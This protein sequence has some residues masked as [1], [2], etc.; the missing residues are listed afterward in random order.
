MGR[1]L[2]R[3]CL[4]FLSFL[5]V[6]LTQTVK[7]VVIGSKQPLLAFP[8][9]DVTLPCHIYPRASAVDM[10]VR[11][12][13]QVIQTPVHLYE[14][15]RDRTD[16]QDRD[17]RSR[18]YLDRAGLHD[19]D[20]SLKLNNLQVSDNGLYNCLA[21]D[22]LWYGRGQAELVVRALGS[23]PTVTL[24]GSEAEQTH[25][26]CRS[27]GWY[28]PPALTWADGHGNDVTALSSTA[29]ERD[30]RGLLRVS[31]HIPVR[32][33]SGVFACLLRSTAPESDGETQVRVSKDFFPAVS[34]WAVTL[35]IMLGLAVAALPLLVIQWRRMNKLEKICERNA[36]HAAIFILQK[37]QDAVRHTLTSE[38]QW[39]S[40]AAAAVTLDPD[41]AHGELTLSEDGMKMRVGGWHSVPDSPRR[42]DY[43]DCAVSREGFTSGRHYWEV[44]SNSMWTMGVSRE[45]AE[46]K[47]MFSFTP[48]EGYWGLE[49]DSSSFCALTAPQTPLPLRLLP[50]T[51]GVCVDMEERQVSFYKVE[52]RAHIYTFT[53]MDLRE[54]E[55]IY[56]FF[57][58][59]D[60][61]KDLVL[62]SPQLCTSDS[63]LTPEAARAD[64][65]KTLKE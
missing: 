15:G 24:N 45:S 28:P 21:T 20:L 49:T 58:T 34:G 62:L 47:G 56:P 39:L 4:F 26:L 36:M 63:S 25:L 31:S 44:E 23:Q 19:G 1:F 6:I 9:G 57:R 17:Y 55:K 53:T 27:E 37:E 61:N 18:T 10:E 65:D 60:W 14:D 54:G 41:T 5:P 13:R 33:Q 48:R 12:Y 35:F 52:S 50:Q 16:V 51:L 43:W 32:P 7:R 64:N 42:F 30:S 2:K 22:G 11:W 59:L 29:V 38:W 8:G 40:S 46:R 3:L